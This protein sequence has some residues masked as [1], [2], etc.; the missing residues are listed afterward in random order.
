LDPYIRIKTSKCSRIS[1][2]M[3]ELPKDFNSFSAGL[4]LKVQNYLQLDNEGREA[5]DGD[6]DEDDKHRD[7][8]LPH[9]TRE[10]FF[11]NTVIHCSQRRRYLLFSC[12]NSQ[13]DRFWTQRVDNRKL[14]FWRLGI[15]EFLRESYVLHPEMSQQFQ[16]GQFPMHPPPPM[17]PQ[18]FLPGPPH[19]FHH[20][21]PG[22]G[23]G[24]DTR[25]RCMGTQTWYPDVETA[26]APSEKERERE[27][28]RE[29]ESREESDLHHGLSSLAEL[30]SEIDTGAKSSAKND[31]GGERERQRERER[32]RENVPDGAVGGCMHG[33]GPGPYGFPSVPEYFRAISVMPPETQVVHVPVPWHKVPDVLHMLLEGLDDMNHMISD[34]PSTDRVPPRNAAQNVHMYRDAID[35]DRSRPMSQRPPSH[36]GTPGDR[37]RERER[38][39]DMPTATVA[40]LETEQQVERERERE[41]V[42][43]QERE[44]RRVPQ[45]GERERERD[46]GYGHGT[47][48]KRRPSF[49]G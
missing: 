35:S 48:A 29:T 45:G 36:M 17:H 33:H 12:P 2:I 49:T 23:H 38:E 10:F 44:V 15:P 13:F 1:N 42:L 43:A 22:H 20:G 34:V 14:V 6:D 8:E 37:G 39:R 30:A 28:E 3:F 46:Q 19:V 27:R 32:E 16:G 40:S 26:S 47:P 21:P 7:R 9:I 24:H 41:R 18:T 11:Q 5:R 31:T 4:W 25:V